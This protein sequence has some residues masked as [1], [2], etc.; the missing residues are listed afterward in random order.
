MEK[1][2]CRQLENEVFRYKK[3]ERRVRQGDA[4]SQDLF[5]SVILR[6]LVFRPGFVFGSRNISNIRYAHDAVMI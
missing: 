5:K 2:A 6:E 1:I 3:I 4:V